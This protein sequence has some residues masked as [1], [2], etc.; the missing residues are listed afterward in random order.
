MGLSSRCEDAEYARHVFQQ[1]H[2]NGASR[3]RTHIYGAPLHTM[4]DFVTCNLPGER[5]ILEIL[6]ACVGDLSML[7]QKERLYNS[8]KDA[9]I[10]N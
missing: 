4:K 7:N 5:N 2:G 10:R 1:G 3:Y 6:G 9:V 8:A